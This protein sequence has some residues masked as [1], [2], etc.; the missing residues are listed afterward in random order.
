MNTH[1]FVYAVTFVYFD[2]LVFDSVENETIRSH[3]DKAF[4]YGDCSYSLVH[5]KE[6]AEALSHHKG[7][8]CVQTLMDKL[9]GLKC[10]YVSL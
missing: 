10:D 4:T 7:E 1:P 3:F 9:A 5:R 2:E 6:L 8:T